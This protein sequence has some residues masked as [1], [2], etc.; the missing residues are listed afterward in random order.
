V[1]HPHAVRHVLEQRRRQRDQPPPLPIELPDDP[2]VRDLVVTPHPL[3]SYDRLRDPRSEEPSN[4][5][6]SEGK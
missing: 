2:R 5:D 3:E 4:D 6:E 1:F